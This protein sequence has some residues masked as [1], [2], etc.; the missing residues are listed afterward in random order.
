SNPNMRVDR[1]Q[2]LRILEDQLQNA[3]GAAKRNRLLQI[4]AQVE[5]IP[6]VLVSK[7]EVNQ[8]L[9]E[10]SINWQGGAMAQINNDL[11]LNETFEGA[12]LNGIL[13]KRMK[14]IFE[15]TMVLGY[16]YLKKLTPIIIFL[17]QPKISGKSPH[18]E[19]T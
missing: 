8:S 12:F 2:F 9:K 3:E 15:D 14:I 17:P 13:K 6:K 5:K 18:E 10:V 7:G 4:I 16:W 11:R 19:I 1:E